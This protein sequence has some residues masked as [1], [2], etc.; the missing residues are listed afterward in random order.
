[1][2]RELR[3]GN[4]LLEKESDPTM[5]RP[6]KEKDLLVYFGEGAGPSRRKNDELSEKER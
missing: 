5:Q 4:G 1:M 2:R 6:R 3:F